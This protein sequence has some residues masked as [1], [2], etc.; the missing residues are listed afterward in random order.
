MRF[1]FPLDRFSMPLAM[2]CLLGLSISGVGAVMYLCHSQWL[3]DMD[4]PSAVVTLAVPSAR[5]EKL[6]VGEVVDLLG[7]TASTGNTAAQST[8]QLEFKASYRSSDPKASY[9]VF[10]QAGNELRY[11]VGERLPGG[12]QLRRIEPDRMVLWRE[13]REEVLAIDPVAEALRPVDPHASA[14]PIPF[15]LQHLR[16]LAPSLTE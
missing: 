1:N 16:A 10:T 2:T 8:E 15:N 13:G 5:G 4:I 11:R 14:Q 7:L 9:V 6:Q 12:S 3:G